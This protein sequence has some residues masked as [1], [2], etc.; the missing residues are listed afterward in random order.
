MQLIV[1]NYKN[2]NLFIKKVFKSKV[3]VLLVKLI[4]HYQAKLI[5][6]Q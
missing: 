2:H 4:H 3:N 6:N 5:K 1:I